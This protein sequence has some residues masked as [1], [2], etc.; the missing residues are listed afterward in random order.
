[1]KAEVRKQI[2]IQTET[3]NKKGGEET[4]REIEIEGGEMK[5]QQIE[6]L[7]EL[8]VAGCIDSIVR[9]ETAWMA[10]GPVSPVVLTYQYNAHYHSCTKT[11][12]TPTRTGLQLAECM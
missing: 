5:R 10:A 12:A 3:E 8:V 9:P 2:Q 6:N 11:T 1:M 7:V 4:N